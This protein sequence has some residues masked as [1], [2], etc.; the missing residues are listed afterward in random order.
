[1]T[2]HHPKSPARAD[3]RKNMPPMKRKNAPQGEKTNYYDVHTSK[4]M[5]LTKEVQRLEDRV[6][7]ERQGKGCVCHAPRVVGNNTK[8][9]RS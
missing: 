7:A 2:E 8:I 4:F 3:T 6:R 1:M 5:K 9:H